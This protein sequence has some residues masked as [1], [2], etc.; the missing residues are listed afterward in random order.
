MENSKLKI[1]IIGVGHVGKSTIKLIED[2]ATIVTYDSATND[3]YPQ[4]E[5]AECDLAMVCVDTPE[6]VNGKADISNVQDAVEHLPGRRVIVRST[7]PPGTIDTLCMMTGKSIVHWPEYFGETS[8]PGAPW[9]RD[10]A[11]VPFVVVGGALP[12]RVWVIDRLLPF[13]GPYCQIF[14]CSARESELVKYMENAFL[15]TKIAFVNEFHD[16]CAALGA[17]W[18]IVRE[19]WLL[20]PRVGRSHSAVFA[21]ARG[22]GGSCLPKDVRA[23]IETARSTEVRVDVLEA[24]SR[25]ARP[26][27]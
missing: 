13:W 2:L 12:D 26:A 8:F 19:G 11:D 15:A 4:G 25:H 24:V 6:G 3:N 16:L 1:G 5:L 27:E 10:E 18:N 20:D 23:I 21:S 14:Q 7:V 17:D 9:R 22:Y